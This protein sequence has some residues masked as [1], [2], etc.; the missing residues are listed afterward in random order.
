VGD[1]SGPSKT[2]KNVFFG[3]SIVKGGP[4]RK[5]ELGL[6]DVGDSGLN[7]VLDFSAVYLLKDAK[8]T[9]V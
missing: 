3:K 8:T 9:Y 6:Y 5:E 7:K 2:S 4:K 1:K